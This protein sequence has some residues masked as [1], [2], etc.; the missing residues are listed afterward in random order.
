MASIVGLKLCLKI[1]KEN[2]DIMELAIEV[3]ETAVYPGGPYSIVARTADILSRV[4]IREREKHCSA[5]PSERKRLNLRGTLSRLYDMAS[6]LVAILVRQRLIQV[7]EPVLGRE[8]PKIE[9]LYTKLE[10]TRLYMTDV[11]P[12]QD[13][14]G[15][16][17]DA[18]DIQPRFPNLLDTDIS[19]LL[20]VQEGPP[21]QLLME[22][23]SLEP[24]PGQD[25]QRDLQLLR[26]GRSRAIEGVYFSSLGR[27]VDAELAFQDSER[28]LELEKSVE[29]HLHRILWNA[30]HRTRVSDWVGVGD[31]ICRAHQVYMDNEHP[32]AFVLHHFPFRFE[33]LC[34]AASRRVPVDKIDKD[35]VRPEHLLWSPSGA[36]QATDEAGEELSVLSPQRLFPGSPGG[37]SPMI[38]IT[39]WQEFV[40]F[41][42]TGEAMDWE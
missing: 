7:W 27:Y 25:I 5:N 37:E 9:E 41:S 1:E 35:H 31:L 14:S 40:N 20:H 29:I 32:S 28:F 26:H 6:F 34:T 24:V 11:D 21:D 38:D 42:S 39:A 22:F 17:H 23:R 18:E 10:R 3:L 15:I 12:S 30:E 16:Q 4:V 2:S 13:S 36:P 19:H 8:N 33:V